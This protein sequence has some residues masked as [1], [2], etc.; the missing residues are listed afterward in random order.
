[1]ADST[2]AYTELPYETQSTIGDVGWVE[3]LLKWERLS[4]FDVP[5]TYF[6]PL[7]QVRQDLKAQ[8]FTK[9][10]IEI[11]IKGLS[12]LPEY[13]NTQSRSKD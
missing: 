13:A 12:R 11:Q 3:L 1:M 9:K 8:G 2:Y 4:H 7:S 6:A 5:E 10:E